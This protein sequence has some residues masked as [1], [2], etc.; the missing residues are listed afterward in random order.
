MLHRLVYADWDDPPPAMAFEMSYSEAL[1][2][3]RDRLAVVQDRMTAALADTASA[4][5]A[6]WDACLDLYLLTPA[7]VNVALNYKVCVEHGL[8]L[9]P[10][11]YF[12]VNERTRGRVTYPAATLA[13]AQRFFLDAIDAS[14]AVFRLHGSASTR[15]DALARDVPARVG[16]FVY[17]SS[18]DKYTWRASEP[19]RVHDLA[20]AVRSRIV[21]LAVVSAAHGAIMAALVLATLLGAPLYFIRF[22]M[23]KRNDTSPVIAPSDLRHLAQFRRGP[24][25]LFDEDVAKGTTMLQFTGHL[26]P[27]FQEAYSA[28]VLANG[29]ASFHPD[30]V[31][32]VWYD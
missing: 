3:I 25:L 5:P 24:V 7:L 10:T 23:F 12:E 4:P 16:D 22:S 26:R 14:L 31:G 15:L 28:G 21:P 13:S 19:A 9:H 20:D 1:R 29:Y 18:P 8:P 30:F 27:F 17:T 32:R 11:F 6:F 2:A